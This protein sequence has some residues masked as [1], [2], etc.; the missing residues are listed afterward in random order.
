VLNAF[1]VN[2]N[3][4]INNVSH[5]GVW[6]L[7]KSSEIVIGDSE[8]RVSPVKGKHSSFVTKIDWMNNQTE[9]SESTLFDK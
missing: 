9:N 7:I 1:Q 5:D 8:T 3:E 6:A 2:M 4:L